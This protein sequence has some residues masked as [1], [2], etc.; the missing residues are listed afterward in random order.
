KPQSKYPML[1]Q[2]EH[3]SALDIPPGDKDFIVT[4]EFKASM[5]MN[6]LSIYPH[7]HY[8]AKVMEAYAT[9]PDGTKKWLVEIKDWDLNWQGVFRYRKPV[10]LPKDSVVTMRYHYDNSDANPRNP[11]S[12]PKRVTGG[13]TAGFEMSHLWL[14]VLP[15][16]EGDQRA[17]LQESL[18]TQKLS[19]HPDDFIAN[20]DMGDLLL[21]K[22]KAGEAIEYFERAAK[23]DPASVLAASELGVALYTSGQLSKAEQQFRHAL[24]IDRS[25]TDARF[26]LASV[27]ASEGKWES[28]SDGF[29]QVLAEKPDYAK[30]S[31]RLGQVLTLWGDQLAKSGKD[32]EAIAKYQEAVPMLADNVDLRIRLGMA[33]ARQE[34][35]AESQAEFEAVLQLKPDLKLA[36]EAIAAIRKRRAETGK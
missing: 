6:V 5:D 10:F 11:N 20:F 12:P 31:Q 34:R 9:L 29:K 14:Q 24:E 19:K 28:S 4:D 8:L 32:P 23:S 27:E 22:S 33:F 15:T 36:Q 3:D 21:N 30:A 25:Y 18:V 1:V 16:A 17:A 2:L 26:N 13:N 35:L 7:A